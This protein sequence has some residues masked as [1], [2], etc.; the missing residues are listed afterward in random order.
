MSALRRKLDNIF[1]KKEDI[2]LSIIGKGGTLPPSAPLSAYSLEIDGLS[3]NPSFWNLKDMSNNLLDTGSIPSGG[4][5]DIIAPNA[6]YIV[7]YA[8][9]TVIQTGVILAGGTAT[10]IVTDPVK[11]EWVLQFID[12]NDV[13]LVYA[14]P[15]NIVT[16]GS[17]SGTDV[18]DI[19]VSTDGTYYSALTFPFTP[20]TGF[21]WFKR[22]ISLVT[23]KY[24]ISE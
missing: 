12:T 23:G 7:K 21:Y 4:T 5:M 13:V 1:N 3:G 8:N 24:T 19:D 18:G 22:S 14:T 16:F 17:G 11:T 9:N 10:I 20:S 6:N 2:R 15:D